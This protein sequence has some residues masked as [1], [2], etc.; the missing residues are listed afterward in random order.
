MEVLTDQEITNIAIYI[1]KSLKIFEIRPV[2]EKFEN[3]IIIHVSSDLFNF[4]MVIWKSDKY[5][6]KFEKFDYYVYNG[7]PY[8]MPDKIITNYHVDN[9]NK[10]YD[11]IDYIIETLYPRKL[12]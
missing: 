3:G 6:I 11:V 2:I 10:V 4:R 8:G 1:I 9:I 5:N 12:Y 7:Q